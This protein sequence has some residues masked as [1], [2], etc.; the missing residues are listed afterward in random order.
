M[1]PTKK[2]KTLD[3]RATI[4]MILDKLI[5]E[6]VIANNFYIGCI[7]A[8]SRSQNGVFKKLFVEIAKD[9]LDDHCKKLSEW[10]KDNDYTVP[11]TFS[12]YEKHAAKSVVEQFDELEENR[13]ATYYVEEALK[14]EDDAIDSY[15]GALEDQDLPL[16]LITILQANL[17]DELEHRDD[18]STMLVTLTSRIDL[19]QH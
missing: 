7:A 2:S 18:L 3:V 8:A 13:D 9:E 4:Q 6:E 15:N 11:Y 14:S 1:K 10:A 5:S 19:L 12:A 17:D 16:T